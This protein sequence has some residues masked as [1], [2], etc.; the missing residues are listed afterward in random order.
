MK[1]FFTPTLGTLCLLS[2]AAVMNMVLPARADDVAKSK[3]LYF[4]RSQGFTH[5]PVAWRTDQGSSFSGEVLK[6]YCA[7]R[8][9]ELVE[10]Q[11]GRVFDGDLD[12]YDGFIFYATGNLLAKSDQDKD[13]ACPI[14]KDG[15]MKFFEAVRSGKGLVGIHAAT[16]SYCGVND[17]DGNDLYTRVMGGRFCGHGP[18]QV[19]TVTFTDPV[20]FP[21]MKEKEEKKSADHEEWYANNHLNTDM[22]VVMVLQTEGMDGDCYH[23]VPY[24]AAWIRMEGSGRVAYTTYGHDNDFFRKDENVRR[25]GEMIEWSVGRFDMDTTTNFDIAT[26]GADK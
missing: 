25:I 17:E 21:W 16:D 19:A 26:P 12:Q 23:R 11:D 3:V 10:T 1:R 6:K 13:H 9:I 20:Q 7:E 8:N 22:H 15:L 14:S 5:G 24:P 2:L 18:M 4:S